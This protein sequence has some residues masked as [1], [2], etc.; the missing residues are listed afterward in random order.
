MPPID[1]PFLRDVVQNPDNTDARLVYADWLEE[2]G[3]LRGEFIRA[4]CMMA[5]L[6]ECDE[7]Y[8]QALER[9]DELLALHGEDWVGEL[10][11]DFKK[12]KFRRGFIEEVTILASRL[13]KDQGQLLEIAPIHWLRLNRVKGKGEALAALPALANLRGLD[14]SGLVIPQEDI[15]TLF[16]SPHLNNLVRF[17]ARHYEYEKSLAALQALVASGRISR[18][19]HLELSASRCLKPLESNVLPNLR[20]LVLESFESKRLKPKLLSFQ[21]PQLESVS[22]I[23]VDLSPAAFATTGIPWNHLCELKF[24]SFSLQPGTISALNQCGAFQP[25]KKLTLR[26]PPDSASELAQPLESGNLTECRELELRMASEGM[27]LEQARP[28]A[29][30]AFVEAL[31]NATHLGALRDLRI[32]GLPRGALSQ[33]LASPGLHQLEQL[34]LYSANLSRDDIL[35]LIHSP[36][37]EGLRRLALVG[38]KFGPGAAEELAASEF[39]NVLSLDFGDGFSMAHTAFP[40]IQTILSQGAFPRVHKLCLDWLSGANR[41]LEALA[42]IEFPELRVLSIQHNS[43]SQAAIQAFMDNNRCD[44]LFQLRVW[45]AVTT[46]NPDKFGEKFG[47]RVKLEPYASED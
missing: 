36:L 37:R 45:G 18:L 5:D 7:E 21:L 14:I 8:Y 43:C 30:T 42:A 17:K 34:R 47:R 46:K 35:A 6:S 41:T 40:E 25:L 24:D 38:S 26:V 44:R 22:L 4:Q 10:Q 12:S 29:H 16:Q 15:Q 28:I 27:M 31:S 9:Q 19:E 13:V 1:N 33:V 32:S 2:H 11:Q 20:N 39:P 3:D 23:N